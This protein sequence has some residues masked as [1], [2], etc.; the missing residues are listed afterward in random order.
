MAQKLNACELSESF[1]LLTYTCPTTFLFIFTLLIKDFTKQT[2]TLV[3]G[4]M[5]NGGRREMR[6]YILQNNRA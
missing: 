6:L 1:V 5:K 2:T 4:V 3:G